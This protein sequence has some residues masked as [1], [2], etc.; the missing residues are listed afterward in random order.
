MATLVSQGPIRINNGAVEGMVDNPVIGAVNRILPHPTNPNIMYIGS[1]NGGVWRTSNATSSVPTWTPLTDNLYSTSIGALAFDTADPTY[2]TIIAGIGR[3]SALAARGGAL[4][5]LQILETTDNGT[6]FTKTEVDGSGRLRGLNITGVVKYGGTIVVSVDKADTANYANYGVFRST[7]N[8]VTFTRVT[9]IPNG[10]AA[11]MVVDPTD[12]STIYVAIYNLQSKFAS[13][14]TSGYGGAGGYGGVYKSVDTGGTWN[15]VSNTAVDD[16]FRQYTK[17]VKLAVSKNG[18]VYVAITVGVSSASK[19]EL[20]AIFSS[21]NGGSTWSSLLPPTTTENGVQYGIHP[22]GQGFVHFSFEADPNN[23][24]IIYIGGD[25]QPSS[26]GGTNRNIMP[27]RYYTPGASDTPNTDATFPNSIGAET[28]SGRLFRGTVTPGTSTCAWVHLTHSNTLG[29]TGGG[30]ANNSAPH[31][32]SRD[33]AFDALGELIECDDGGIYRRTSPQTNTGDWNSMNGNLQVTEIHS[34]VYDP[35]TKLITA[36]TQDNGTIQLVNQYSSAEPKIWKK[37]SP[38]DGAV[39]CVDTLHSPSLLYFSSQNLLGFK[40]VEASGNSYNF[41]GQSVGLVNST[42]VPQFYTPIKANSVVGGRLLL[43]GTDSLYESFDKGDTLTKIGTSLMTS[44]SCIVYGGKKNTTLCPDLVYACKNNLVF[45]RRPGSSPS[46]FV[47]IN[48]F[49]SNHTYSKITDI[50]VDPRD[51]E[52]AFIVTISPNQLSS[53]RM[54]SVYMTTNAG[55]TWIDIT[56]S[57]ATSEIGEIYTCDLI[58]GNVTRNGITYE[59]YGGLVVGTE[60]GVWVLKRT[61]GISDIT[62]SNASSVLASVLWEKVGPQIP[63]AQITDIDYNPTDDIL[64]VGTLGRGAWSITGLKTTYPPPTGTGGSVFPGDPEEP[65]VPIPVYP[66]RIS[67]MVLRVTQ[68]TNIYEEPI[69]LPSESA[70]SLGPKSINISNTTLINAI[71]NSQ[72]GTIFCPEI[73]TTYDTGT[74]TVRAYG[75]PFVTP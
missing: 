50:S 23:P 41:P 6:T 69:I 37:I 46:S 2:N 60:A 38:G 70:T 36:G 32:D 18:R 40:R 21:Q 71:N 62:A 14:V 64:V 55:G 67:S 35:A 39:V 75:S 53:G 51:W 52:R 10:R 57:L 7:D 43:A 15:K 11:D 54:S 33:M 63:N 58:R 74:Y 66:N 5:G 59:A 9:G 49:P 61:G 45:L 73:I 44:C 48:P 19:G 34:I 3:T 68:G 17:N 28:Y 47:S 30:T 16:E 29:A 26:F 20:R 1:V 8:G 13:A 4:S 12:P 72:S 42:F 22:G 65:E 31:A 27:S 25:R 56:G 24:D